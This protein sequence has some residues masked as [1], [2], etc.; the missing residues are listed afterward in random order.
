MAA[1]EK[2][3]PPRGGLRCLITR[4][5]L[6]TLMEGGNN[7]RAGA[8]KWHAVTVSLAS[9]TGKPASKPQLKAGSRHRP[10]LSTKIAEGIGGCGAAG[11]PASTGGYGAGEGN[12]SQTRLTP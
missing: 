5:A 6:P 4:R 2:Q 3:N 8:Y 1:A 12:K 9:K 7:Q 11:I 10:D